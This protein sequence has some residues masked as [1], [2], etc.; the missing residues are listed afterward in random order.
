MPP[1]KEGAGTAAGFRAC[2]GYV[3]SIDGF[4][5]GEA[6]DADGDTVSML[7]FTGVGLTGGDTVSGCG[8]GEATNGCGLEAGGGGGRDAVKGVSTR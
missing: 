6:I 5:T 1:E 3:G 2:P 4:A 7:R 8:P